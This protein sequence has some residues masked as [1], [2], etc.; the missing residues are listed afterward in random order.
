VAGCLGYIKL[1]A[2]YSKKVCDINP[3]MSGFIYHVHPINHSRLKRFRDQEDLDSVS[4]DLSLVFALC[5]KRKRVPDDV[6]VAA[7]WLMAERMGMPEEI[8]WPRRN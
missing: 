3:K 1:K 7:K 2:N 6:P 5:L 4:K 8:G